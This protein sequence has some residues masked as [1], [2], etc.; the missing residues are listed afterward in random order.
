MLVDA[1]NTRLKWVLVAGGRWESQG[2]ADYSDLSA[3]AKWVPAGG[4]CT[5]ASVAG[6]DRDRQLA[7]LL[8][9]HEIEPRWLTA[10]AQFL[11]VRNTYANP[12][13]LGVDRWMGLIAARQRNPAATLVVSLGTALTVDALSADGVFLG[14]LI[15]PG[16]SLMQQS[17]RLGTAQIEGVD[18]HWQ[19][20]P[21]NTA[22][23]VQSGMVAAMSGAIHLQH[24]RLAKQCGCIPLCL[25]T[26]GDAAM[27]M[28]YLDLPVEQVPLLVLEGIA[29]VVNEGGTG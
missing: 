13:Q 18:G 8:S 27:L 28:P 24:A 26:G 21:Q 20:F 3:L 1:G 17:L 22:D 14:G 11:E 23:A 6:A 9:R 25:L 29:R 4:E 19:A 15:I 12:A 7:G 5:I 10:N 16:R 2:H